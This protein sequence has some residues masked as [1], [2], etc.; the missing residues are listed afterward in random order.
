[1]T[2][3]EIC[4]AEKRLASVCAEKAINPPMIDQLLAS[5]N[6]PEPALI[7]W[8]DESGISLDHIFAGT[9]CAEASS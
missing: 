9:A 7:Q 6:A 4:A 1:M 5:D 8:C 3:I 2:P